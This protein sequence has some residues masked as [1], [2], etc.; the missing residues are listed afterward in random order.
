MTYFFGNSEFVD[1]VKLS[2]KK[3]PQRLLLV[4]LGFWHKLQRQRKRECH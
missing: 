4:S 3:L 2:I 1:E